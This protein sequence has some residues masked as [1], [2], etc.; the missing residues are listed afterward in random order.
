M[1]H[2]DSFCFIA[3]RPLRHREAIYLVP[4]LY[5]DDVRIILCNEV[6]SSGKKI[7]CSCM[8]LISLCFPGEAQISNSMEQSPS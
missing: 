5:N 4:R 7:V 3:R 1:S 2:R 6:S 8:K